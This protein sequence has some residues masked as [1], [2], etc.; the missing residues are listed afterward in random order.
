[1]NDEFG[2]RV[3]VQVLVNLRLFGLV[4][5]LLAVSRAAL[6]KSLLDPLDKDVSAQE[7]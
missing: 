6:I 2:A 5:S 7:T 4:E 3:Q 1:M